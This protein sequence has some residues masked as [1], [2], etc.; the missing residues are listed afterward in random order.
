[1]APASPPTISTDTDALGVGQIDLYGDL[2][3]IL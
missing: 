2:W 3:N 1:M